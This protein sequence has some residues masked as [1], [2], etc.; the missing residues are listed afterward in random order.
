MVSI[1]GAWAWILT[2]DLSGSD[3]Q[4]Q[5]ALDDQKQKAADAEVSRESESR[6]IESK[7][8][9]N[10]GIDPIGQSLLDDRQQIAVLQD[11]VR[12]LQRQVDQMQRRLWPEFFRKSN[13]IGTLPENPI[14]QPTPA[15]VP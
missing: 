1:G 4:V 10:F 13:P 15:D 6:E 7:P 12:L 14:G 9:A 11:Q 8:P 5:K 2:V 3:D